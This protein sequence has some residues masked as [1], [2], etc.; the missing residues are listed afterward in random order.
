MG[1]ERFVGSR[2]LKIKPSQ[3]FISLITLLSVAGVTVGVMA[4]IVVIAVM[5]GFEEDLRG[6]IVGVES[7]LVILRPEQM[8]QVDNPEVTAA[9]GQ[10]SGVQAAMPFVETQVMLRSASR[11]AGARLKGVSLTDAAAVIQKLDVSA[12][13]Q[14]PADALGKADE[15]QIDAP[16]MIL[17]KELARHLGLIKGDPV[18][19]VNPRGMLSPMGHVPAMRR[20]RVAGF[21]ESGMYEYDSSLAFM[22]LGVAQRLLRMVD[23]IDGI[24]L[25]LDD[26]FNAEPAAERLTSALG[27]S[28]RIL[29]WGQMNKNLFSALKLEKTV[30]FIILALIVLVAAFNIASSLIMMVIEK[31]KEIAILKAMGATNDSIRKIFVFKG[32]AIGIIGTAIG[33]LAGLG[34]CWALK[35]YQFIE[36]PGD[37]YY[38]TTL[39]VVLK[40]RDVVAIAAA[41]VLICFLS[42]LYP[43]TQ[44][45]RL[46]PVEAIRYG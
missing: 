23:R 20:F 16:P 41:A 45:A 30:M 9:I 46:Q 35:H 12:L 26:L 4:L 1:F 18:Y 8:L 13:T 11:V 14:S 25:R 44:A 3:A 39:P 43:A 6:R 37:V 31:T 27:P 40:V 33:T 21:F 2:Y 10:L 36:L 19:V 15:I 34:L 29:S 22:E 42:T 7:H 32:L 38:I 24:D 5:A 17:G 28:Y